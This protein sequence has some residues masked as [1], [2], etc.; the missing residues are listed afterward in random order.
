MEN[1]RNINKSYRYMLLR[2]IL[3]SVISIGNKFGAM[4]DA[5]F[6]ASNRTLASRRMYSVSYA[7]LTY[8]EGYAYVPNKVLSCQCGH[9]LVD[10]AAVDS[11]I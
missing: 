9:T 5:K 11:L 10:V 3:H 4:Y 1:V 7:C 8:S 2:S 6:W